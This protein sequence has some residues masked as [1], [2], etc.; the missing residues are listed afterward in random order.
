MCVC[1]FS[2]QMTHIRTFL[3]PT[4]QRRRGRFWCKVANISQVLRA[5]PSTRGSCAW[6]VLAPLFWATR[7]RV[8]TFIC[9]QLWWT[10]GAFVATETNEWK[11]YS[12]A[13]QH[14][15]MAV[16]Y[17][18]QCAL[19]IQIYKHCPHDQ[20]YSSIVC[21]RRKTLNSNILGEMEFNAAP[22]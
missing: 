10:F 17:H 21:S 18:L 22:H 15:T 1:T 4:T 11:I 13:Q 20:L 16:V 14:T 8:F 5:T 7:S 2:T 9:V 12:R 19:Y 6:R 3:G